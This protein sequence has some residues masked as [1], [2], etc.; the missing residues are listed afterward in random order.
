MAV[1]VCF[2]MA[3][4]WTCR[5]GEAAGYPVAKRGP[6]ARV[7]AYPGRAAWLSVPIRRSRGLSGREA[8]AGGP[9]EWP[10]GPRRV[11]RCAGKHCLPG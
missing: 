5:F 6:V 4:K 11:E 3:A 1:G 2:G 10:D 9:C 8:R 7:R